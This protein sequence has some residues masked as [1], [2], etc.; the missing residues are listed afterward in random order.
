MSYQ[1]GRDDATAEDIRRRQW[2][3]KWPHYIRVHHATFIAGSVANGISL[4]RLMDEL[5][6]SA[7]A[8]T[9]ANAA[10]GDGN[11]NPRMSLRRQP[12]ARLSGPGYAWLQREFKAALARHGRL[13]D[14]DLT[15]LDWPTIPPPA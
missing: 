15:R 5:G 1:D 3:E 6:S 8:S 2:K 13:P 9:E 14:A 7:F 12:H 11:T 10:A 4:N